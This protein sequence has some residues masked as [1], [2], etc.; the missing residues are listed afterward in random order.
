MV[1]TLNYKP[2]G[3]MSV[4][5]DVIGIFSSTYSVRPHYGLA[6]DSASLTEVSI[7]CLPWRVKAA[8]A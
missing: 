6:V 1:E 7:K 4:P 3:R 8:G 2:E 5:D